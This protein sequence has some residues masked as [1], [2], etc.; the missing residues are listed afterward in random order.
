MKAVFDEVRVGFPRLR[1][2]Y[3]NPPKEL[4]SEPN[5]LPS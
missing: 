2:G 1:H 5:Q 4:F 3:F